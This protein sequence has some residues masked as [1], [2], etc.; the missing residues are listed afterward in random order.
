M[1]TGASDY[2]PLQIVML[3]VR[4]R[5]RRDPSI[6]LFSPV[7]AERRLSTPIEEKNLNV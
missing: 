1:A 2:L 3:R 5:V 7:R 6:G 4:V